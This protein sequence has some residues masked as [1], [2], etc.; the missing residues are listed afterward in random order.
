VPV[1]AHDVADALRKRIPECPKVKLQKLLY[2]CQGL[3]LALED[4]PMFTER[5][6]AWEHGPVVASLW[7]AEEHGHDRPPP[8]PLT[9][10][11]TQTVDYVVQR[12]GSLTGGELEEMSH[13]EA[14]WRDLRAP[15]GADHWVLVTSDSEITIEALEAWFAHDA[16]IAEWNRSVEALRERSDVYGFGS[17]RPDVSDLADDVLVGKVDADLQF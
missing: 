17:L 14:P 2:Y 12:Y 6:E 15:D 5:I 8:T 7:R 9:D 13:D 4:E 1:S 16:G 11:M 3:H 10:R